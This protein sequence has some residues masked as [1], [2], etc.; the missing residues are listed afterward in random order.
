MKYATILEN[1]FSRGIILE[2]VFEL[3]FPSFPFFVNKHVLAQCTSR[4][5]LFKQD[6]N[7]F[8][9]RVESFQLIRSAGQRISKQLVSL[10]LGHW[11]RR[12]DIYEGRS[13]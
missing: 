11:V 2:R 1:I 7:Y 6:G 13:I 9:R 8:P 3:L 5:A 4:S 10:S 12:A